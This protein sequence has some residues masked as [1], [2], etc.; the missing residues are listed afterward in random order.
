MAWIIALLGLYFLEWELINYISHTIGEHADKGLLSTS[1]LLHVITDLFYDG[2]ITYASTQLGIG[3]GVLTAKTGWGHV[4]GVGI[5]FMSS[6]VLAGVVNELRLR[7]RTLQRL[8]DLW[9]IQLIGL[10]MRIKEHKKD[11]RNF[12][13][14]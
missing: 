2:T 4:I 9:I 11:I 8:E 14:T 13:I 1:Y 12:L 5:A 3:A 10:P 6:I 7:E